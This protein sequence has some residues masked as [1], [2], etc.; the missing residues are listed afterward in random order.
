MVYPII[1]VSS[2]D[3]SLGYTRCGSAVAVDVIRHCTLERERLQV[4][5]AKCR[6]EMERVSS[7]TS[8]PRGSLADFFFF[9][10]FFSQNQARWKFKFDLVMHSTFGVLESLRQGQGMD[11]IDGRIDYSPKNERPTGQPGPT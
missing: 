7:R 11:E 10:S 2:K 9:P 4:R 3:I 6:R 8:A 1:A 5:G